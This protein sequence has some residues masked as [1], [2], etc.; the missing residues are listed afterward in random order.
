MFR[1]STVN[2]H[3]QNLLS[4]HYTWMFGLSFDE[5]VKEQK[6]I[7][8]A[9]T[10]SLKNA[11][12]KGLAVDL[13]SGSGFQ[14]IALAELGFSPVIAIDTSAELLEELRSHAAGYSV[15][16]AQAD[17]RDLPVIVPAGDVAVAVCM[18]DTLTHL[19]SKVDVRALFT[20]VFDALCSGGLFIITYRDLTMELKGNDRFLP[21]RSDNDR[22]MT[23]FLEYTDADTVVVHDLVHTR[24]G[25]NWTL[26][27]SS[28][29]KL[30]LGSGWIAQELSATGF[31]LEFQGSA[32]RL[33]E[34][35]ASKPEHSGAA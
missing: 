29:R 16:G 30:R 2:E 19:P 31:V 34:I 5:K 24:E 7:L 17:L 10:R 25:N 18:G 3:Y 11:T 23:C 6:E 15:R 13:G 27:K 28:Y 32:G 33:L 20:A 8:L 26:N 35:V 22:I 14:A 4:K 21:I 9:A 12:G 1:M